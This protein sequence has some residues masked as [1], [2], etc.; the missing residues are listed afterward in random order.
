MLVIRICYANPFH[1]IVS[2]D[3]QPDVRR[4]APE[5]FRKPQTD[6]RVP[7]PHRQLI[8]EDIERRVETTFQFTI[9]PETPLENQA[10]N[11]PFHFVR[12]ARQPQVQTPS[13]IQ[14]TKAGIE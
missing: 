10:Q 8:R 14:Q 9:R 4:D 1:R 7:F 13:H 12:K 2:G 6:R 5:Q 3:E 11:L